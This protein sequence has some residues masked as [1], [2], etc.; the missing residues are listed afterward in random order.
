MLKDNNQFCQY[1][2]KNSSSQ[3]TRIAFQRI[4]ISKFSEVA[5]FQ[6][7]CGSHPQ[8]SRDSLVI[9]KYPDFTYLKGCTVCS[10]SA[11]LLARLTPFKSAVKVECSYLTS[12]LTSIKGEVTLSHCPRSD[13]R[14]GG[15]ALFA[16][17]GCVVNKI[18]CI[19]RSSFEASEWLVNVEN[20]RL[21]MTTLFA[22]S[23]S[24]D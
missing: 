22:R 2:G 11:Y 5:Y 24:I 13:R 10:E 19:E 6:I 12:S 7:P 23:S 21:R 9:E 18:S 14:G 3:D 17:N 15:T 8:R 4:K 16:R 1:F 20:T